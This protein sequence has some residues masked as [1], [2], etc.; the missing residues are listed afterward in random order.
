MNDN[1]IIIIIH[2]NCDFQLKILWSNKVILKKVCNRYNK[3]IQIFI[4][5][6]Y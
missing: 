1:I 4:V 2:K 5:F 6:M 3:N